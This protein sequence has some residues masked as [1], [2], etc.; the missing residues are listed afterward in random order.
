[1]TTKAEI[2]DYIKALESTK[3]WYKSITIAFVIGFITFIGTA[4]VSLY[5]LDAVERGIKQAVPRST[6]M[7]LDK[8][9]EAETKALVNL[10][11]DQDHQKAAR[12]FEEDCAK[13][14]TEI[15]MW[16][17]EINTSRSEKGSTK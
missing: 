6:I 4:F 14:R 10:I 5:R 17:S 11:D 9:F 3:K 13:I 7:Q 16:N 8:T 12:Q 2:E 15:I 1:M